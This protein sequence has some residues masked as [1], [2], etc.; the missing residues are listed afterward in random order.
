MKKCCFNGFNLFPEQRKY[1]MAIKIVSYKKIW[2]LNLLCYT[3]AMPILRTTSIHCKYLSTL[4]TEKNLYLASLSSRHCF[5]SVSRSYSLSLPNF[6]ASP[7]YSPASSAYFNTGL[8]YSP[9]SPKYSPLLFYLDG[10][11]FPLY[12]NIL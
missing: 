2:Y 9:I 8:K 12:K 6:S 3:N 4:R 11:I 10:N 1:K 5:P 7:H